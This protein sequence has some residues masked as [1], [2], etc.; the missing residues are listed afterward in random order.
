MQ[1]YYRIF[2]WSHFVPNL[3]FYCDQRVPENAAIDRRLLAVMAERGLG[4][5]IGYIPSGPE[6][7][8]RYFR[9]RQVY[10]GR[11]G[12]D[13]CLFYDLDETHSADDAQA[14]FRCDAIH[15]SG[16]HTG[17]FLGR[18]KRSGMLPLLK[19]WADSGG[20][21]IGASAGAII[22]TP[23]IA[24]DGL[25][26]GHAPESLMTET[27]LDLVP[28]EFFP[29]LGTRPTY[30]PELVRYSRSTTRPILACNDGDGLVVTKSGIE[31]IGRPLWIA[32]GETKTADDMLLSTIPVTVTR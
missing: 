5:R 28:F 3:A 19:R 23:T 10:Y 4:R 1:I 11:Y 22:M 21:L 32:N 7:S 15:L 31:C 12:L 27:A 25:F 26:T 6:P 2:G 13:L 20:L 16:G 18:L 30:L 17:G 9:D 29:H 14:L 24:T 8:R